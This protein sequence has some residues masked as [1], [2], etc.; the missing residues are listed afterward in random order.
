MSCHQ[1][2]SISS[3]L[4]DLWCGGEEMA[5]CYTRQKPLLGEGKISL[6]TAPIN[7]IISDADGYLHSIQKP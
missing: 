6:S 4:R 1:H 3:V 2:I 5:G 7:I